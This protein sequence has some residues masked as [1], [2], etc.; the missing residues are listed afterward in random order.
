MAI[1]SQQ[2]LPT[3]ALILLPILALL[4]FR[5]KKKKQEPGVKLPPGPL[6]LPIIGNLHQVGSQP[7]K[8]FWNLSQKYGPVM[9]LQLGRTPVIVLSSGQTAK[10]AMKD[11]D[12]ETCSRPCSVGPGI[13]TYNFLDV[14]FAPY[15]DYWKEIKKLFITELLSMK[16]VHMYLYER[17]EQIDKLIGILSNASPNPVNLTELVFNVYDGFI[18][19]VAFGRS[20][21]QSEF[22]QGFVEVISGAMDMLNGF[23]AEDFFPTA[24][25]F[26][27]ILTGQ[28]AKREKIFRNLD[29]YFEK[30]L[31]QHLDPNRPKPE[32]GKED[33]VDILIGLMEDESASFKLTRDNLKSI[34]LDIFLGGIDTSAATTTWALSEMLKN[35]RIMRKAQEEIRGIVGKANKVEG[36]DIERF[37][38]LNMIFKETFRKHPP[39]PLLI[40]HECIK[41]CKIG[42]YDVF[43]GTT[44]MINAYAMGRD[45]KCWD[46]PED[47]IPE[48]F[49]NS[50]VDFKGSHFELLPFGAGRRICP[51]LAMGTTAVM[52]TLSNLLYGFDFELPNGMKFEEFPLIEKGG[53]TIHNKQQLIVIPN[54]YQPKGQFV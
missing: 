26:I 24:G 9:Q 30:V 41:H 23:H 2:W 29:D 45:P 20:F 37:T 10:E 49:E 32:S 11:H 43:P 42:G 46:N 33:I 12:L 54:K 47:F 52:H 38:Y 17:E 44:V 7:Y 48:R 4:L 19:T 39:L 6:R 3:L 1:I 14:V 18:G 13:L 22:K 5:G 28:L 34:I 15:S 53:L 16:R 50:D 27:D 36:R 31:N 25:K 35:P 40:P 51:G 21:G 8:S